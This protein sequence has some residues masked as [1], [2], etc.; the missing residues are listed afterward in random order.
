MVGDSQW[1]TKSDQ[2]SHPSQSAIN[3]HKINH[4]NPRTCHCHTATL[5]SAGYH[6]SCLPDWSFNRS[7]NFQGTLGRCSQTPRFIVQ[8]TTPLWPTRW[9]WLTSSPRPCSTRRTSECKNSAAEECFPNF[10]FPISR[11]TKG[12]QMFLSRVQ[13]AGGIFNI[14]QTSYFFGFVRV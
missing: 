2:T 14:L 8:S 7:L 1:G 4:P 11:S 12:Q 13:N 10:R 5:I 3:A 6:F 9:R